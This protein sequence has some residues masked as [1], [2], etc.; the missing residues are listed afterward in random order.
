[1]NYFRQFC[2]VSKIFYVISPGTVTFLLFAAIFVLAL[3][4]VELNLIKALIDTIQGWR[5]GQGIAPLVE[6]AAYLA[7]VLII[8][9]P[10]LGNFRGNNAA[11]FRN[12]V[13]APIQF[14]G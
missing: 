11:L 1:M 13:G 10:V 9:K 3:V 5:P 4:P 12:S 7:L 8:S 14:A 6:L 2:Q